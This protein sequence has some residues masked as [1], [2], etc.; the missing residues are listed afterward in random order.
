LE[1]SAH[2]ILGRFQC[3]FKLGLSR[4]EPLNKEARKEI[5]SRVAEN[6]EGEGP[7]EQGSASRKVDTAAGH[8]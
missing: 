1:Q 5:E 6:E 3:E 7:R 2:C 4:I 8:F